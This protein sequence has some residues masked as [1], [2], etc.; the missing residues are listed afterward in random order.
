MSISN[1]L[2]STYKNHEK[3]NINDN[4]DLASRSALNIGKSEILKY[5]DENNGK[6]LSIDELKETYDLTDKVTKI[7]GEDEFNYEVK[8]TLDKDKSTYTITSVVT[9]KSGIS[10]K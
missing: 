4:I 1:L 9:N 3:Y 7:I 5:I 10:A 2:V 6:I 8:A